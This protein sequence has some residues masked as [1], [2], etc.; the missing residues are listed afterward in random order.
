MKRPMKTLGIRVPEEEERLLNAEAK[1]RGLCL[2]AHGRDL[3]RQGR[4]NERERLVL[5][6]LRELKQMVLLLDRRLKIALVA[7]LVDAG[8]ASVEDAEAFVRDLP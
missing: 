1:Q 5:E 7:I 6:E 2:S 4:Q 8:K 3:L